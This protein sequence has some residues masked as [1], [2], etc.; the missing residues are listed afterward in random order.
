MK[1]EVIVYPS[2]ICN[3]YQLMAKHFLY[4]P[5]YCSP[6]DPTTHWMPLKQIL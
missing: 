4:T 1:V 2:P 3:D 5:T 6:S